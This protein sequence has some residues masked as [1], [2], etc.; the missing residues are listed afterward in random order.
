M[1]VAGLGCFVPP[2]DAPSPSAAGPR[3]SSLPF[4]LP[5]AA[6]KDK[7]ERARSDH[8]LGQQCC[9]MLNMAES[10]RKH[11]GAARRRAKR[12]GPWP[13]NWNVDSVRRG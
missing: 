3:A 7:I 2:S 6:A 12:I 11:K 9:P 4:Y 13:F 5:A 8:Q 10:R 1:P